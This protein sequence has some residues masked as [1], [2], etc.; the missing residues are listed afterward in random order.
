VTDGGGAGGLWRGFGRAVKA[1]NRAT[2][3][4][5]GVLI[6]ASCCVITNEVIWR[7]FLHQPHT[8]NLELNIFLLIAATFLAAN[9]TQMRR[10]HVGTEVLQAVLPAR[11]NR[12]RIRIGDILS[13]VLLAFLAVKVWQYAFEAWSEGWTTD[14]VWAP[15][16][17]I[18]YALMALGLT[19]VALEYVVQIGDD[20]LHH[21]DRTR[22]DLA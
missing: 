7:Y 8:W 13:L 6:L 19:L 9:Y 4:L 17:W 2:G 21:V 5:S 15:K 16:L 3:V 18:P 10:G 14:S 1:I 12:W 22:H 11:W 20:F